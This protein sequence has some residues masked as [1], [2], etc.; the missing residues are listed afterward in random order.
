MRWLLLVVVLA[1]CS[2]PFED[3][4]KVDTVE[5]W[6][7]YLDTKPSGSHML[8]AQDRLEE[9]MTKQAEASGKPEDYDAVLTQFPTTR[10]KKK[11]QEARVKVAL[12]IATADNSAEAWAKF[13]KENPFAD[14][15]VRR[16]AQA[17]VA[18]ANYTPKLLISE[19]V[20]KQVNLAEDPKGPLNG[21]G[22]SAD[23]TNNGDQTITRLVLQVDLLDA[24]G[25]TLK[26]ATYPA[27]APTFPNG[28]IAP[29]EVAKPMAPGDKRT[30]SY[31]TDAGPDGWDKKIKLTPVSI[32]FATGDG[33]AKDGAAKD[34]AP[35]K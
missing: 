19:P 22:F 26:T 17:R 8:F 33:A 7:K 34:G 28:Q 3:T 20:V 11:L 12:A 10:N 6:Q 18:V 29:D 14:P 4:K 16:Q 15:S 31:T 30:W 21:W 2:D 25:G 27:V 9:L 35:A 5:A 32:Q 1:G 24:Q 23:V 13:D